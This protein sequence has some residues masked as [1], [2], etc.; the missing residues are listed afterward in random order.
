MGSCPADPAVLGIAFVAVPGS[1]E[2]PGMAQL[3]GEVRF[4]VP[5]IAGPWKGL[6]AFKANML[7]WERRWSVPQPRLVCPGGGSG[8]AQ[9]LCFASPVRLAARE[10]TLLQV[11][12]SFLHSTMFFFTICCAI[13]MAR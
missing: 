2:R 3:G 6:P 4:A 12:N 11:Y 9:D 7:G 8:A 10:T 1:G 5:G 13:F